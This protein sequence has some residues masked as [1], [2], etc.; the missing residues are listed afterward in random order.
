MLFYSFWGW[1]PQWDSSEESA[2]K[3]P[4]NRMSTEKIGVTSISPP[5]SGF[6]PQKGYPFRRGRKTPPQSEVRG[7]RAAACR[8]SECL[9]SKATLT[10]T[11]P[12]LISKFILF[13]LFLSPRHRRFPSARSAPLIK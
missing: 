2:L 4:E 1:T 13:S 11:R 8:W 6:A 10:F 12:R 5:L 3:S 7:L 9:D